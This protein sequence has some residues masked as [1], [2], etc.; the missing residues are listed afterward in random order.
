MYCGSWPHVTA[1]ITNHSVLVEEVDIAKE[2]VLSKYVPFALEM[3]RRH[4]VCGIHASLDILL[5]GLRMGSMQYAGKL[6]ESTQWFRKHVVEGFAS[7]PIIQQMKVVTV[8]I[9]ELPCQIEAETN[10]AVVPCFHQVNNNTL[11]AL[12]NCDTVDKLQ[13]WLIHRFSPTKYKVPKPT[14]LSAHELRSAE[15]YIPDFATSLMSLRDAVEK[16]GGTM[17]CGPSLMSSHD[18][19]RAIKSCND[20]KQDTKKTAASFAHRSNMCTMTHLLK[21]LPTIGKLEIDVSNMTPAI[22]T[23]F[24]KTDMKG[25]FKYPFTWGF[26]AQE[27]VV[28]FGMKH[29]WAR[30]LAVLPMGDTRFLFICEGAKLP[31]HMTDPCI[32]NS[33]LTP[34]YEKRFGKAISQIRSSLRLQGTNITEQMAVGVGV[35]ILPGAARFNRDLVL[36]V[37]GKRTE[38]FP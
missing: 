32:H 27:S 31:V 29:R 5:G 30:V 22:A 36:R 26:F 28:A 19:F 13:A 8:A 3:F 34:A 24:I 25:I 37:D 17:V 7:L 23:Q 11:D 33:M 38:Y 21:S 16:H 2:R 6:L 14:G 20:D 18:V 4:G 35:S 10:D 9:C 1:S 15:S 12:A